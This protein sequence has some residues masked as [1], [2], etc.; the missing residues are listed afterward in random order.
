LHALS[1]STA[2]GV[3]SGSVPS[4]TSP[5]GSVRLSSPSGP[6]EVARLLRYQARVSVH[7]EVLLASAEALEAVAGL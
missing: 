5:R 6:N 3:E 2:V 4:L 7:G 1:L